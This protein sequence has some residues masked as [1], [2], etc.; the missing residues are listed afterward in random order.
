M[1]INNETDDAVYIKMDGDKF[2]IDVPAKAF[3][4][5]RQGSIRIQKV[6]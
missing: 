6:K 1:K 4:H 2:E 3:V 5:I